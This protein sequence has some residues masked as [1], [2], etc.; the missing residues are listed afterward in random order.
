MLRDFRPTPVL[1]ARAVEFAAG[2]ITTPPVQPRLSSTVMLLRDVGP[3]A[4]RGGASGVEV[5]VLR[6]AATMAFA[7]QMHAFPGGG[8]DER[9]GD[10]DVPWVGPLPQA[11]ASALGSSET[12]ARELVCAAVR[13][14]F[15]ECGV[16][17][18]GPDEG[19]VVA[20]LSDPSWEDDRQALLGR[21]LA[22]SQLLLR[23]GLVL[24]A[25]LLRPWAHW[26]TPVFEPR[27]YDTRFFVAALPPGQRAREVGGEADR[28][29]WVQAS[30]AAQRFHA[31]ELA[32][33]PPT[34][35]TLEELGAVPTVAQALAE[36]RRI[37][38]AMPWLV[39][40]AGDGRDGDAHDGDTHDLDAAAHQFLLRVDVD[41]QGGGRPGPERGLE[42]LAPGAPTYEGAP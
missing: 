37:G 27:R 35:I 30:V 22:L 7:A 38:R 8:V 40:T 42:Q 33:L 39:A 32:M 11:W 4:S 34:I 6:R 25:D 2:R 17:L 41:G 14:L 29:G 16:L 21:E 3:G 24:R 36:R 26:T 23:R 12:Q 20:D 15:E 31:G 19:S 13:E 1:A 9:D 28:A 18:A 5:F 10:L